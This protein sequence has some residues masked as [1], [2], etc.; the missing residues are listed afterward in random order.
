MQGFCFCFFHLNLY[1]QVV[2]ERGSFVFFFGLFLVLFA[3]P[4]RQISVLLPFVR[5]IVFASTSASRS[6]FVGSPG[7][8]QYYL[9]F[10]SASFPTRPLHRPFVFGLL[11]HP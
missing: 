7:F 8:S 4:V 9:I 11:S 5:P 3:L 10:L 2:V 1:P 6:P